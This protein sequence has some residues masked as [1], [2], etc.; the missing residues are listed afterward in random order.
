MN[1]AEKSVLR[2]TAVLLPHKSI[3]NAKTRVYDG[4][5]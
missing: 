4:K 2:F 1:F 5:A 3:D